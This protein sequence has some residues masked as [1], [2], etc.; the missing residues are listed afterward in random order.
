MPSKGNTTQR[1]YGHSHQALRKR[2]EPDVAA[3][4][5]TCWRCGL[6]IQPGDPWDLGHTDDRSGYAGPEH[7]ACNRATA[8][9]R[10]DGLTTTAPPVDTSRRW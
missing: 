10:R 9:R 2:L 3:G 8:G 1:G 6:R 5:A 7:V 4:R